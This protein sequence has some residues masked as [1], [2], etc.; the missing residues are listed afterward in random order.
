MA[1]P[2]ERRLVLLVVVWKNVPIEIM[3]ILSVGYL[4]YIN[5]VTENFALGKG[6]Q[7]CGMSQEKKGTIPNEID[8]QNLLLNGFRTK[9][10]RGG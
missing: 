9:V 3:I 4:Q 8:I 5:K 6:I 7:P 2:K 1:F 10:V